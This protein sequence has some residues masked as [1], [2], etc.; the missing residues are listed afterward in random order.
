LDGGGDDAGAAGGDPDDMAASGRGISR[1][2]DE[3]V[4][5]SVATRRE[6]VAPP[7]GSSMHGNI[8]ELSLTACSLCLRVL[9]SEKWTDAESVIR[10]L[11][12]FD[13]AAPPRFE[14]ALCPACSTSMRLRRA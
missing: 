4:S 12:S 2:F 14:P 8:A 3:G 10:E 7:A 11:H 9:R 6:V 13:Y 1:S 5:R